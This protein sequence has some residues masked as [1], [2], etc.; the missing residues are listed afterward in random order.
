MKKGR[1]LGDRVLIRKA[2]PYRELT[3]KAG[4]KQPAKRR[5]DRDC[6]YNV[7]AEVLE[8]GPQ[9]KYLKPGDDCIV[10]NY[11]GTGPLNRYLDDDQFD[12]NWLL[13]VEERF[14]LAKV[15]QQNTTTPSPVVNKLQVEPIGNTI[16]VRYKN[17]MIREH[18][19][20][21][22]PKWENIHR[23]TLEDG[24]GEA[25][26][27]GVSSDFQEDLKIGQTIITSKL[28]DKETIDSAFLYGSEWYAPDG[29]LM[30]QYSQAEVDGQDIRGL[31][32][33]HSVITPQFIWCIV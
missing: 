16:L 22:L 2:N 27:V 4:I 1:I 8:V 7:L 3:S 19:V 32:W 25:L 12:N 30:C 10:S 28:F 26:V 9:V 20:L 23:A 18:S 29:T 13:I 17:P 5:I 33:H 21:A 24:D 15:E 6:G 11:K 14:I 31:D